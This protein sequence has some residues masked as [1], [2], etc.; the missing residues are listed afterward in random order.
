METKQRPVFIVAEDS[1]ET[2][3]YIQ[4]MLRVAGH[5]QNQ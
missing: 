4:P 1:Q 5:D 3:T 2:M